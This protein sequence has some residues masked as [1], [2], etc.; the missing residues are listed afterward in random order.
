MLKCWH[1]DPRKRSGFEQIK[2][3]LSKLF[4]EEAGDDDYY[5]YYKSNEK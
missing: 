2:E 3:E 1:Y 4:T 5:M